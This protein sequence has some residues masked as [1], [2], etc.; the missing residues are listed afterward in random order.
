M[1]TSGAGTLGKP[2]SSRRNHGPGLGCSQP[3]PALKL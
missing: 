3:I 2:G 1:I